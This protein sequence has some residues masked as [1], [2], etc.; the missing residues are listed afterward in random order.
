M[1]TDE[2]GDED[3]V[4]SRRDAALVKASEELKR[5]ERGKRG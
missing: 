3:G 4:R 1:D 2:T 5:G